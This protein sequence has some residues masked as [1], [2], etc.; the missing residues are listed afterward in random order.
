MSSILTPPS[1]LSSY[2]DSLALVAWQV[3]DKNDPCVDILG[4]VKTARKV[5]VPSG[6]VLNRNWCAVK[7]CLNYSGVS[8]KIGGARVRWFLTLRAGWGRHL[9]TYPQVH[10][11]INASW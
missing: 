8:T 1:L 9:K 7:R 5:G 4:Q 3:S 2:Q 6:R 10:C 11:F